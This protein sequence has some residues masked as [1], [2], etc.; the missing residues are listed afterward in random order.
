MNGISN[1]YQKPL[2]L[3][4][5]LLYRFTIPTDT[6]AEVTAG[7]G[8]LAVACITRQYFNNLTGMIIEMRMVV[9]CLCH[10][11]YVFITHV[12]CSRAGREKQRSA[13]AAQVQ[14]SASR[15][16]AQ[17][18]D[19]VAKAKSFRVRLDPKIPDGIHK[20]KCRA[21]FMVIVKSR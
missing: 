3:L 18:H 6:V 7:S 12:P 8:S 2:P 16:G 5:E 19:A 1:P 14:G 11:S 10:S 15:T 4:W 21:R 13:R 9:L 20:R 17:G